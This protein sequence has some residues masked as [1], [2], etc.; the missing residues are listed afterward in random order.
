MFNP[1]TQQKEFSRDLIPLIEFTNEK[2]GEIKA[3]D[4]KGSEYFNTGNVGASL[5]FLLFLMDAIS[6]KDFNALHAR[7]LTIIS[8]EIAIKKMRG[9]FDD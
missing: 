5:M 1:G 3:K 8:G 9:D 2:L 7:F 4:P 6:E